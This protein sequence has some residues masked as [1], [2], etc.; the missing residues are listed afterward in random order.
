MSVETTS[1]PSRRRGRPQRLPEDPHP[2]SSGIVGCDQRVAWLLTVARV[3]GPDPDLARRDGFIA[4]LKEHGIPVDASRVSRWESGL[5]PLPSRVAA[6]YEEVLGLTEGSLV[7]VASGLRRSF[8]SGPTQRE[9]VVRETEMS[10]SELNRLIDINESGAGNGAQWLQLADHFSRFDR[11]FLR[12]ADWTALC[13]RLVTEL[14][15]A[16]GT[17]YVRRYEAA[18]AFIRHPNARR[19]LIMAVGQFVT[20][21][22]TQVVSPV[23]NL[24][25]EVPDPAAAALTLRMLSADSENKYLRRAASSVAATKLA[26]G[27]F[28][29]SALPRLESHVLGALRRGE[30]L[31]GRLDSFDLAVRLPDA[32][33]ERVTGGLRTRRALALVAQARSGDEMIPAA[34]A[35]SV[36]ADLAPA[37]QADTPRHQAQE[38]DLMLRRLLREALFHSHKP[39]RHHA[40]LL[41]AATPYAPSAA[42]HLLELAAD[43][44]ELLAARAWTVLMRV[45]NHDLRDQV[46]QRALADERP[47][48]RSRALVNVGLDGGLS[49][50]QCTALAD[51]Y[52]ESRSLE[53]HATLFALGMAGAPQLVELAKSEDADTAR[54]AAWW[55]G[56]GPAIHDA[57]LN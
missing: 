25:S 53:R 38:P 37:V 18:A 7:A 12:E 26:R 52:A 4:A 28:D 54:G 22:D 42:R 57:D 15:S 17:S 36:V 46:M 30:S 32:S 31:D 3:L 23:L 8:G 33:W 44:N 6:T 16:V 19:H 10:D 29:E 13:R 20:D 48:V 49:G 11:V 39:R 47:T 43:P 56:Q 50:E 1:P 51:R 34:R 2:L 5:Q 9:N 14:G 45:G 21:P 55:L 27:H 24:L 35:A 41:I 40:A